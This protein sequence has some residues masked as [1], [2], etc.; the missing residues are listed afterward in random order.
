MPSQLTSTCNCFSRRSVLGVLPAAALG[1]S[2][3]D[4]PPSLVSDEKVES[5]GLEAWERIRSDVPP[6]RASRLQTVLTRVSRRLLAAADEEEQAWEALVFASPEIN[7]FVLPGRKIG[8]FEGMFE[9]MES[10]D[11]LAA[12]VGHEIGHLEANHAQER[13]S[14]EIAANAGLRII[15]RLLNLGEV[16]YADEFA[17]ALGLGA[18]VGLLLP[19]S[20]SHE[21]EADAYGLRMMAAAGFAPHAALDLWR[22]MEVATQKRGPAFLATHPSPATRIEAMEQILETFPSEL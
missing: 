16:E 7:A 15:S 9:V 8:V 11:Q 4:E 21:L 6:S 10:E 12:V 17:A 20:R 1:L 19:Y 13:I 22:R 18:Q 3:C 2:G 14:A 5:M